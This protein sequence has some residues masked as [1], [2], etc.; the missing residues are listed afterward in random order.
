MF[1]EKR[2]LIV[3]D[4]D[5]ISLLCVAVLRN[6]NADVQCVG[7]LE[8][9]FLRLDAE[10]FDLLIVDLTLPDGDGLQLVQQYSTHTH[11]P[12]LIMTGR[13]LPE[14]RLAGFEAGAT[15][16]LIKPFHPG[17]LEH[18]ARTL[19]MIAAM[20]PDVCPSCVIIGDWQVDLKA[21]SVS[22]SA[23]ENMD[24]T[25]GEFDL[26]EVLAEAQGAVVSRNALLDAVT[27][28]DRL[29]HPRTVDVLISRLRKK[30]EPDPKAA[31]YILT[32]PRRGYRL[33]CPR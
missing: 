20:P 3:E 13:D 17:E 31:R 21:R 14:Q 10:R 4:D 29:G 16:Y 33:E 30:L 18:R 12:V 6:F 19:L 11:T 25:P 5:T 26:L 2:V 24:L 32:V 7:T 9:A 23:N 22:S 8:Q 28:H 15:D 27:Q 1:K